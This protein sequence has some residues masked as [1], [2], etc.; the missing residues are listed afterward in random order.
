MV[1]WPQSMLSPAICKM[2]I[3]LKLNFI[4]WHPAGNYT[5]GPIRLLTK[6]LCYGKSTIL[7]C[8]CC[9]FFN[10]LFFFF[11]EV[12][13]FLVNTDCHRIAC[14]DFNQSI[15]RVIKPDLT[16]ANVSVLILL[17]YTDNDSE[18]NEI[19]SSKIFLPQLGFLS[20]LQE[21]L[22]IQSWNSDVWGRG[23]QFSSLYKG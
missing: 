11:E 1:A 15:Y 12:E 19:I 8:V 2:A 23:H 18:L 22:S 13:Q 6:Q 21:W 17:G 7:D 10:L 3:I 4:S 14:W 9:Y 5:K 16:P 20:C